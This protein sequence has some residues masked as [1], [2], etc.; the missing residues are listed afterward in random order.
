M[1]RPA[2][3]VTRAAL[4]MTP[5]PKG[6]LPTAPS[7]VRL[8]NLP[9]ARS[10]RGLSD[11]A[12][13]PPCP[14]AALLC[15]TCLSFCFKT[16]RQSCR[17]QSGGPAETAVE[18]C[19]GSSAAGPRNRPNSTWRTVASSG[20]CRLAQARRPR[21]LSHALWPAGT[22]VSA[23][24]M[25]APRVGLSLQHSS[26]LPDCARAATRP[27]ASAAGRASVCVCPG[28]QV[29]PAVCPSALPWASGLWMQSCGPQQRFTASRY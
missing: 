7:T 8:A 5:A 11:C 18:P 2:A 23:P 21:M 20:P 28:G 6:N 26:Q 27:Q 29:T 10:L 1:S 3:T 24:W 25:R 4:R 15:K 9:T 14:E 22:T 13:H 16:R 17:G 19:L 12:P